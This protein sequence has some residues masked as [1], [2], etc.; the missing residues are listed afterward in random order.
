MRLK[1]LKRNRQ[2]FHG[3]NDNLRKKHSILV[4]G[5]SG[6]V[7]Y[8]ILRSLKERGDCFLIGTTIYPKSPANCFSDVV[9]I[10]PQTN[11]PEYLSALKKLIAR[12]S[13]DMIIPGIE[14]D[15]SA[16]NLARVELESTGT[17]VLLNNS[18]L[19]SLC[20]D[21]WRFYEKLVENDYPGRI[22]TSITPDCTRFAFPFLLKPR[23]GFGGRGIIKIES[24]EQFEQNR[25][26]IGDHLMMQEYVGSD[27]EEYT[28]S[29]FFDGKSAVR[30]VMGLRRRLSGAG[31]TEMAEVVDTDEFMGDIKLLADIFKPVGPTN[32][33]FRKDGNALKLLEM[34][35]RISSSTS[36]RAKFG[37]NESS[38]AAAYF[39]EGK[40]VVQPEIKRGHAM[41]YTEEYIFYDST[42][43]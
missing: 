17:F 15:M 6:I 4:S 27:A 8:G 25:N 33:Q 18:D 26:K 20:L 35:P 5:A 28:I 39:L 14:A 32:F 30:A 29:A 41:R 1:V 23:C 24:R 22:E 7:G 21:K 19:I 40:E 10:V 2:E 3:I 34:N 43:I 42:N 36:I 12:Y 37:Y 38:M 16:W 11:A 13:I 31:Y 9:E